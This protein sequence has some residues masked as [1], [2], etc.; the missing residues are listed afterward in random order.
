MLLFAFE[1]VS[2]TYQTHYNL[3]NMQ[4]FSM[5]QGYLEIKNHGV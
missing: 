2:L 5:L 4:M 1:F 3:C